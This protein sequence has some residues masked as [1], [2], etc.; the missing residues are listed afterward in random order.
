MIDDGSSSCAPA[1]LA[2]LCK[3][4]SDLHS[5][6][7]SSS[8]SHD[9]TAPS[10][11]SASPNQG[12][13]SG[14]CTEVENDHDI[15][16]KEEDMW[17]EQ[18]GVLGLPP[19]PPPTTPPPPHKV[20]VWHAIWSEEHRQY[21]YCQIKT[22]AT[23]WVMPQGYGCKVVLARPKVRAAASVLQDNTGGVKDR[24]REV[25]FDDSGSQEFYKVKNTVA[26]HAAEV[27]LLYERRPGS[28]MNEEED[29]SSGEI[30]EDE[31]NSRI[32]HSN[33]SNYTAYEDHEYDADD[34]GHTPG[35]SRSSVPIREASSGE[36][37]GFSRY[38]RDREPSCAATTYFST[39]GRGAEY[40]YPSYVS[41]P[42]S[43]VVP[44]QQRRSPPLTTSTQSPLTV[45]TTEP[46]SASKPHTHTRAK[47]SSTVLRVEDWLHMKQDEYIDRRE[48]LRQSMVHAELSTLSSPVINAASKRMVARRGRQSL[49]ARLASE[50]GRRQSMAK[51]MAAE[52]LRREEAELTY[53]PR[54]TR[55]GRYGRTRSVSDLLA[56]D[57]RRRERIA[58]HAAEAVEAE[59]ETLKNPS[60]CKTSQKIVAKMRAA[61][62][63]PPGLTPSERLYRGAHKHEQRRCEAQARLEEECTARAHPQLVAKP[64]RRRGL[65]DENLEEG[66]GGMGVTCKPGTSVPPADDECTKDVG[67]RLYSLAQKA[68]AKRRLA[69]VNRAAAEENSRNFPQEQSQKPPPCPRKEALAERGRRKRVT[70][71]GAPIEDGLLACG[72]QAKEKA[73]AAVCRV[74]NHVKVRAQGPR[75][76][77][78]SRKL[79]SQ[80]EERF[81]ESRSE[82]LLRPFSEPVPPPP[83][84]QMTM[85]AKSL[86]AKLLARRYGAGYG[87][88][89]VVPRRS[90]RTRQWC[91]H[92]AEKKAA[93]ASAVYEQEEYEL[94]FWPQLETTDTSCAYNSGSV[95]LSTRAGN[96]AERGHVFLEMR[97][98]RRQ[99]AREKIKKFE[100]EECSFE[101]ELIRYELPWV[102]KS[103][104]KENTESNRL[105]NIESIRLEN[106]ESIRLGME[107]AVGVDVISVYSDGGGGPRDESFDDRG[108]G[109][110]KLL[111]AGWLAFTSMGKTYY[112]N[113][114]DG[115]TTWDAP[116]MDVEDAAVI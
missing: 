19:P 88:A 89:P 92:V 105:E 102:K 49:P 68:T 108:A 109:D 54:L 33:T 114:F 41:T 9:M 3:L 25:S 16:D 82:T 37:N 75:A 80:V 22:Q 71:E 99:A 101:P 14:T 24:R 63:D 28:D 76:I 81:G 7:C 50:Q 17:E 116:K 45:T 20:E 104:A 86:S 44:R 36:H 59:K 31:G 96:I 48:A 85:L 64:F 103:G 1:S 60:V 115:S 55:R 77:P 61:G 62:A 65:Q 87:Y 95:M 35:S 6:G 106:T 91:Q 112:Y 26:N 100:M 8:L 39:G 29:E 93:I 51:R 84:P 5:P 52:A 2:P 4:P 83:P 23:T 97:E 10:T 12:N 15:D 69:A 74:E 94:T 73:A 110:V 67:D 13:G 38:N 90:A 78:R 56:F 57:K 113:S 79:A 43:L 98:K 46:S 27:S 53:H 42:R 72:L 32:E 40:S 107:G 30:H 111:P 58:K 18:D 47:N 11:P 34:P 66:V 21:Y 70:T